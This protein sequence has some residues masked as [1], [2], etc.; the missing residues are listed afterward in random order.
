MEP[1]STHHYQTPLVID[2]VITGRGTIQ[3]RSR[4]IDVDHSSIIARL[5]VIRCTNVDIAVNHHHTI[6]IR[7]A[8]YFPR[9]C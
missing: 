7:S 4:G 8:D 3:G 9:Y 2:Q 5:I 6:S 1:Q